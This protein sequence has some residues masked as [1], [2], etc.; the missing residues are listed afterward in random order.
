[1]AVYSKILS[2]KEIL[3]LIPKNSKHIL[4]VA[5]GGCVNESLAYDHDEPIFTFDEDGNV[6]P[7]AS[8][9]EAKRFAKFLG[10]EGFAVDIKL[11]T[12]DMPVLC[13]YSESGT[14][15]LDTNNEPDVILTLSCPSGSIGLQ[16]ITDTPVFP[17][18]IQVGYLSY[19]YKDKDGK[20]LILRDSSR[21]Q[22]TR[23][24]EK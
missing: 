2:D 12:G 20:R 18:T 8:N 11:L 5:C 17:I 14:D 15:I 16:V 21:C 3:S 7:Y 9:I 23:Q 19:T 4:I 22:L 13:I 6:T 1:M 10:A 24:T